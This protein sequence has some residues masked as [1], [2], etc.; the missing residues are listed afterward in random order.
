MPK[1]GSSDRSAPVSSCSAFARAMP[2]RLIH[3]KHPDDLMVAKL[4][5]TLTRSECGSW[6]PR[7]TFPSR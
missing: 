5:P 4:G 1:V 3:V 7:A 2:L 6:L